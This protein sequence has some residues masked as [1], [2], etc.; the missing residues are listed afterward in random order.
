M[1][2]FSSRPHFENRQM[3]Q[4]M[5]ESINLSGQTNFELGGFNSYIYN[6]YQDFLNGISGGTGY[7]D[8]ISTSGDTEDP[9]SGYTNHTVFSPGIVRIIPPRK[10]FFSG[11]TNVISAITQEDVTGY[12]PV[13]FD[14]QGTVVWSPLSAITSNS[15]SCSDY[16]V[17]TIYPCSSGGTV[18][19]EGNLTVRGVTTSGVTI[20]ETEI[21]RVEDNNLE[22]NW[23]G[24]HTTALGGGITVLSGQS[25]S[26]DSRIYTLSDGT[27]MFEPG[28]SATTIPYIYDTS[29]S[30]SAII[31]QLGN[32]SS[33]SD[34][35][36]ILAGTGNTI[37]TNSIYST[38]LGGQDNII[39]GHTYGYIIGGRGNLLDADIGDET[40]YGNTHEGIIGSET[41]EVYN[42][43]RSNIIGSLDSVIRYNTSSILINGYGYNNG[44]RKVVIDS[45][46]GWN[47]SLD[48][49]DTAFFN[50]ING[51]WHTNQIV[52]QTTSLGNNPYLRPI[53]ILGHVRFGSISQSQDVAIVSTSASTYTGNFNN[54]NNS[55]RSHILDSQY[56]SI[57]N[58]TLVFIGDSNPWN[59]YG[60]GDQFSTIIG[61][62]TTFL[63]NNSYATS[64]GNYNVWITGSSYT[65]VISS[66]NSSIYGANNSSIFGG[67]SNT[68]KGHNRAYIIGGSGN[69]ID[70]D[71]NESTYLNNDEVIIGSLNSE[72]HSSALSLIAAANNSIIRRTA[73]S[74]IIGA[75]IDTVGGGGQILIDQTYYGWTGTSTEVDGG[76]N[77]IIGLFG[78]GTNDIG[79]LGRGSSNALIGSYDSKITSERNAVAG[80]SSSFNTII[81]GGINVIESNL[82]GSLF[83]SSNSQLYRSDYST[84][85]GGADHNIRS[86]VTRSG[87]FAGRVNSITT[88]LTPS[89]TNTIVGGYGNSI[90][91]SS[92]SNIL[93]GYSNEI[94]N[95][96][97]SVNIGGLDNN[98]YTGHTSFIIGGSGHYVSNIHYGSGIIG[99]VGNDIGFLYPNVNDTESCIIVGGDANIIDGGKT[100]SS[101]ISAGN[102]RLSSNR[103]NIFGGYGHIISGGSAFG[104]I[105]GGIDNTIIDGGVSVIIGGDSHVINSYSNSVILGGSGIVA[106]SDNTVYVPYLNISNAPGGTPLADLKIDSNGNV[107]TGTTLTVGGVGDLCTL[108]NYSFT[109]DTGTTIT[110]TEGIPDVDIK[111]P[112]EGTVTVECARC[113]TLWE[114]KYV[115]N[116]VSPRNVV[117]LITSNFNDIKVAKANA[118]YSSL[119]YR[120]VGPESSGIKEGGKNYGVDIKLETIPTL[121]T[122]PTP[123]GGTGDFKPTNTESI[124]IGKDVFMV[125]VRDSS[126]VKVEYATL[127]GMSGNSTTI[128]D[129]SFNVMT[130][131]STHVKLTTSRDS[132]ISESSFS[133]MNS[134][135]ES[136]LKGDYVTFASTFNAETVSGVEG[137][138]IIA[139]KD[140]TATQ[141]Y[142]LYTSGLYVD[143]VNGLNVNSLTVSTPT[144][145]CNLV[146]TTG[147]TVGVKTCNP[148]FDLEVNGTFG[149]TSKSFVIPHPL[150]EG[151]KLVHGAI[152]GPEFGVYDRGRFFGGVIE[153]PDYWAKLV[154]ESTITV[155]LTGEGFFM[156]PYVKE[157]RDNKVFV[158]NRFPF[159]KST[160][161]YTVYGERKDID[162]IKLEIDA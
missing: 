25:N 128:T 103:V 54:I 158:G 136:T 74:T 43:P 17:S 159:I 87:I 3:V 69:T 42:S 70:F 119:K 109:G 34:F 41:S 117:Y 155:Q 44:E 114:Y 30:S 53:G 2:F 52:L 113:C 96:N 40:P 63:R 32:N 73:A 28:L 29:V 101:I 61:S 31:P 151:K 124:E 27:W 23:G 84:I 39:S 97:Y 143:D 38:I 160:G 99:G 150:K 105:V 91:K 80:N 134:T 106:S 81:G 64:I 56:S 154:D 50:S 57:S 127:V 71:I 18:T 83:G 85:V 75:A 157:I 142:T 8:L 130:Y 26:A 16:Y 148:T 121:N 14:S 95:S 111:E 126:G 115:D 15:G 152:E 94:T 135:K 20:I 100:F 9:I 36:A 161:F 6:T 89:D 35:T 58:S 1:A 146:V 78:T 13:A 37:T 147:G 65:S 92:H 133:T 46:V 116:S 21:V 123:V 137:T 90:Y 108:C 79:I 68:I 33:Q 132:L 153:L 7:L 22:L 122:E 60:N 138:A 49:Y 156:S 131:D 51:L 141:D 45:S 24:N 47:P 93:A 88:D 10:I 19:I 125:D 112:T 11:N 139:A 129:T 120:C 66:P 162:K 149:A 5:G 82:F 140:I 62:N 104:T 59:Q 102:S 86:G 110:I 76:P 107:I 98:L 145:S 67:G 77:T 4:W 12:I 72:I 48:D 118:S 144:D 55:Y